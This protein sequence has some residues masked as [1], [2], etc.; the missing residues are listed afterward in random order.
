SPV[1]DSRKSSTYRAEDC[2][3]SDL[4]D[5]Y[6]NNCGFPTNANIVCFTET[7]H[8]R[9]R[10]KSNGHMDRDTFAFGGTCGSMCRGEI[11]LN[12]VLFGCSNATILLTYDILKLSYNKYSLLAQTSSPRFSYSLGDIKDVSYIY[13]QLIIENSNKTPLMHEIPMVVSGR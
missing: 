9:R 8:L 3:T 2:I 6:F 13:N 7:N 4:C 11:I 10:T 1:Y 5:A 12:D